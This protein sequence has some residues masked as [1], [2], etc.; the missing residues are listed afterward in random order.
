MRSCFL[1][2]IV[3]AFLLESHLIVVTPTNLDICASVL[4]IICVTISGLFR[5]SIV[6]VEY[7]MQFAN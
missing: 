1:S 3:F 5:L 4:H 7:E 2:P 6:S